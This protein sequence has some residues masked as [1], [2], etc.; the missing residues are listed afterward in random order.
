MK[1]IKDFK[2]MKKNNDKIVMMTAYDYPSG[3]L[4][5]KS[6][7]DLILAG[8]SLGMTV[9][10]YDST[11]KVTVDDIVRHTQAVRRGAKDT[12]IIADL[13][14]GSY[15]ISNEETKRNAF[16]LIQ[17]GNANAVKLEGGSE[18]RIK[19]ISMLT[20]CEIPVCAHLGLTPQS[21]NKLG[22]YKI[23]GKSFTHKKILL[24]QAKAIEEAGA[25]M[26]VL[27]GMPEELAKNITEST[28]IPAIG[29]GAG[30][31]TDGQVMVFHDILNLSNN[32]ARFV[33]VFAD[34]GTA[35]LNGLKKYREEVKNGLYPGKEHIYYPLDD[36]EQK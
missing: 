4:A 32:Q 18:S 19:L 16:R 28:S 36:K 30:K 3:I 14:Y 31:Y 13:P 22:G 11:L 9:L 25:F 29:I 7:I 20:D 12:F 10:G 1:T 35:A 6:G 24:E 27:E 34:V 26:L 23:Q 17:E 2:K 33:K 15:H 21:V 8:D 5:E